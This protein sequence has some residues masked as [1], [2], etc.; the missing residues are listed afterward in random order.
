MKP[1]DFNDD[2][3]WDALGKSPDREPSP[4]F[5][6]KVMAAVERADDSAPGWLAR[7]FQPALA[8][9]IALLAAAALVAALWGN[10]ENSDPNLADFEV[11]LE[12]DNLIAMEEHSLWLDTQQF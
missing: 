3:L 11:I 1:A 5:T 9:A 4:Y 7:F 6:R 10:P 12:L 8:G 2:S